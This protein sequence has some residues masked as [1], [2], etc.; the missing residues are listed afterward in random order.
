[1]ADVKCLF[2]DG[3]V[4][5]NDFGFCPKCGQEQEDQNQSVHNGTANQGAITANGT[6][7]S[8]RR[9]DSIAISSSKRREGLLGRGLVEIKEQL[10]RDPLTILMADPKVPEEKRY[11]SKC[12]AQIEQ[13]GRDRGFCTQ[14]RQE[15]NYEP[16]LKAGNIVK[17]DYEVN[18][19]VTFGGLGWIYLAWHKILSRHVIFKGLLNSEDEESTLVA[20][21]ERD[22]LSHLKH[23]Q[24]V[25]IYDFLQIGKAS[26]IV[27]EFVNGR[28]I[29]N[30]CKDNQGGVWEQGHR[31]RESFLFQGKKAVHKGGEFQLGQR[32]LAEPSKS[33]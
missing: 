19:C 21:K 11:C 9:I 29:S 12:D 28:T 20:I 30:I 3:I 15:F 6:A 31:E 24:I 1:M 13:H 27:M 16:A 8:R 26:Y 32:G 7:R 22:F 5:E 17:D 23:P 2:C 14:C 10:A 25:S 18:G 4:R 33:H